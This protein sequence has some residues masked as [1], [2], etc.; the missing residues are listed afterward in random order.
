MSSFDLVIRNGSIVDG[1]G[2]APFKADIGVRSGRI[3]AIGSGLAAGTEE[4]DATGQIV[5]PGFVD[6]H[7]HYDGQATWDERLQ[8]S[9][10][11][12]VTTAVMGNCGVGFAPCKP[13][14]HDRLIRLMVV[15]RA[16]RL[17]QTFQLGTLRWIDAEPPPEHL[18]R[19]ARAA[20]DNG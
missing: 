4:I 7:T 10:W 3:A 18:Q 20:A 8:P 16:G 9:S 13:Q 15:P 1:T 14:D 6:I 19:V 5:T 12:G 17:G 11:H 2:A